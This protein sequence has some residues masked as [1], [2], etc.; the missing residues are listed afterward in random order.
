M[1][2]KNKKYRQYRSRQGR[3]DDQYATSV[4]IFAASIVGLTLLLLLA[5]II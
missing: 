2:K 5:I 4:A 3:S 1:A